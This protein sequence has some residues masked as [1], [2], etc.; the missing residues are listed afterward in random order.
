MPELHIQT[1]LL[2]PFFF[3]SLDGHTPLAF[4]STEDF[5]QMIVDNW[6]AYGQATFFGMVKNETNGDSLTEA[7]SS[8]LKQTGKSYSYEY[9]YSCNN[10]DCFY[11]VSFKEQ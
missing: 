11:I 8:L 10:E 5:S 6:L 4:E 1:V 7:L 3:L 9:S 2:L